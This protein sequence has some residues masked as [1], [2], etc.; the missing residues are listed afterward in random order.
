MAERMS[1][2]LLILPENGYIKTKKERS[3]WR[4]VSVFH[5]LVMLWIAVIADPR[6]GQG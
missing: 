2:A 5:A 1:A 4:T 6:P 3:A